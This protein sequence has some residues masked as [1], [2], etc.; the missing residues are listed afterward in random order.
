EVK[1]GRDGA[2]I[3]LP[4]RMKALEW[5]ANHMDL[6]TERQRAEIQ[7]LKAEISKLNGEDEDIEDIDDIEDEIYGT[8]K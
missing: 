1:Q 5:L 8:K 6:A 7:K 3:K 2:S 4:D